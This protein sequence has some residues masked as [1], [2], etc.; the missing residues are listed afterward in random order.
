MNIILFINA[1]LGLQVLDYVTQN[2]GPKIVA[3]VLNAREKRTPSYIGEVRSLLEKKTLQLP[4]LT[5]D[6]SSSEIER[7]DNDFKLPTYGVSALF[8]HVLPAELITK[9]SGGII[10]LH[11]SLLP[12]GRG[13]HPISWSIVEKQKQGI[14]LHLIDK[15][16]DTGALISQREIPGTIEMNAGDIYDVAITELF[17]EFTKYFS[18][19]LN[20][21]IVSY[22][23]IEGEISMH[24]SN[25]LDLLRTIEER[26]IGTFGDFVRRLQ[27][28]TFSNGRRPLFKDNTGEVWEVTFRLTKPE[29]DIK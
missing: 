11:P 5:W 18:K 27:A 29:R 16:L 2:N 21:E 24:K 9:F 3:V 20:G 28:N 19:W 4:I 22:P 15:G 14:S 13:A 25:E 8:G 1:S 12:Q 17:N 26:E 23:Q 7:F 10:N 6:G